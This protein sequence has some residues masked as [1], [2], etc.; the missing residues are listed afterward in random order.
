MK[1]EAAAQRRPAQSERKN[2]VFPRNARPY[3]LKRETFQTENALI[4]TS[5]HP[6][7]W[8]YFPFTT[9]QENNDSAGI[10][11]LFPHATVFLS[12]VA[13]A[14]VSCENMRHSPQMCAAIRQAAFFRAIW[15]GNFVLEKGENAGRP[16]SA[17]RPKPSGKTAFFSQNARLYGL[18]RKMVQTEQ[19]LKRMLRGI[20]GRSTS[21]DI[22]Y[23]YK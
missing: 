9:T 4:E 1:R 17:T 3:G 23:F 10:A 20:R 14:D 18:A 8:I 5:S 7:S 13:A 12:F 16:R 21:R 22:D 19:P 6:A 11:H 15:L 2:R